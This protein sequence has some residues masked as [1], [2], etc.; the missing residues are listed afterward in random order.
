[1]TT[2]P[3][4]MPTESELKTRIEEHMSWSN[5][6]TTALIWL[7]YLGALL[8]WGLI[9]V[10]SHER[11]Q[12]LLPT[13][14]RKELVEMMLGSPLSAEQQAELERQRLDS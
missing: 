4:G 2:L 14:G 13:V 8:E 11:L 6:Q 1:M 3:C 5:T 9:D 7:G 10:G 12:N